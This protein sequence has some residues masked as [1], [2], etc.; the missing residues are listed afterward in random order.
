MTNEEIEKVIK[1]MLSDTT[2]DKEDYSTEREFELWPHY[3]LYPHSDKSDEDYVESVLHLIHQFETDLKNKVRKIILFSSKDEASK[4]YEN[5]IKGKVTPKY[6]RCLF[7][8]NG[9]Y[10]EVMEVYGKTVAIEDKRDELNFTYL[11][12]LL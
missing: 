10:K 3:G 1:E 11:M 4:Y 8:T 12:L 9:I 2:F 5:E 7:T 6:Y